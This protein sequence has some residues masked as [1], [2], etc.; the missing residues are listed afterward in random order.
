MRFWE[1]QTISA[2]VVHQYDLFEQVGWSSVDDA[3][4]SSLND[5]QSLI[6]INQYHADG[7]QI[8]WIFTANA[9]TEQWQKKNWWIHQERQSVSM[10]GWNSPVVS[11]VRQL[12]VQRHLVTEEGIIAVFLK[13]ILSLPLV[14]LRKFHSPFLKEIWVWKQLFFAGFSTGF[15]SFLSLRLFSS[16]RICVHQVFKVYSNTEAKQ[17]SV[18]HRQRINEPPVCPACW[19]EVRCVTR[20]S[21][22]LGEAAFLEFGFP[23]WQNSYRETPQRQT[24]LETNF[25][26]S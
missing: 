15:F 24:R 3:A 26:H 20:S 10:N 17:I 16:A 18:T 21:A 8:V 1:K 9:S 25:S 11:S 13:E 6:Q 22:G 19:G 4:N 7:G 23:T 12:P 2:V 14:V 5:R